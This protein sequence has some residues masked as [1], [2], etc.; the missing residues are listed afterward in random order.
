MHCQ[1]LIDGLVRKVNLVCL[2]MKNFCLL[3]R[4]QTDKLQTSI[5]TTSKRSNG[6]R[7]IAWVSRDVS[8]SPCPMSPGFMSLCLHFSMFP[9]FHVYVSICFHVS[10]ILQTEN[11]PRGNGNFWLFSGELNLFNG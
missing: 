11:G 7:K 8:M 5:G 2:L 9:C 1:I 3:L 4:Q 10:G 6:L